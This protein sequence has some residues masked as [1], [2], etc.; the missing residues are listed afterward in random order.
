MAGSDRKKY[1]E[2]EG[3]RGGGRDRE[4]KVGNEDKERETS[5]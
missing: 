4:T 1:R 2:K 3:G 5:I